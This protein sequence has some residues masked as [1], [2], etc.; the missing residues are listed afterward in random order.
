MGPPRKI[1]I[2]NASS[3]YREHDPDGWHTSPFSAMIVFGYILSNMLWFY[4]I[5][6][7]ILGAATAFAGTI[8]GAYIVEFEEGHI[9]PIIRESL[10]SAYHTKDPSDFV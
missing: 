4:G 10:P 1:Q 5:S 2:S 3:R 9:S 7:I 6:F 8:P